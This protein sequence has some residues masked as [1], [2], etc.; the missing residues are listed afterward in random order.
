MEKF[1]KAIL[2]CLSVAILFF[3][4]SRGARA[5][6]VSDLQAKIDERNQ[7]ELAHLGESAILRRVDQPLDARRQRHV[8]A[9]GNPHER[10][11]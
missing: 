9:G 8:D 3:I 7:T 1:R 6:L 2:I 4:T 10:L 5:D 11:R